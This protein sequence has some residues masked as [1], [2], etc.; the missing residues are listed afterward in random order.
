MDDRRV[1]SGHQMRFV[2]V[3]PHQLFQLLI[4]D[5]G[6]QCRVG[7]LVLVESQDRKHSA[8]SGWIEELGRVPAAR[9]RTCLRLPIA[10]YAEHHQ[11]RLIE[12]GTES[13]QK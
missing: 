8:V 1:V 4:R 3:A 2:A 9:Q 6:E 11:V 13:V 5:A 7:D 12:G 10:N